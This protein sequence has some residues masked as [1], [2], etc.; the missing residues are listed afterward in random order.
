MELRSQWI[1]HAVTTESNREGLTRE[2]DWLETFAS[3]VSHSL[4]KLHSARVPNTKSDIALSDC[5]RARRFRRID[6]TEVVG[7]SQGDRLAVGGE[8]ESC[9]KWLNRNDLLVEFG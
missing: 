9:F 4:Q 1:S 5:A 8:R 3:V 2:R 7:Y 6:D